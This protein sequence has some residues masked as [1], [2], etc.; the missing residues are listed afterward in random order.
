MQPQALYRVAVNDYIAAGGS[1]FEVLKRNTTK[2]DT[3]VS[4]RDAL[5][6]YLNTRT[7]CTDQVD[8][9]V[10]PPMLVTQ[11]YGDISCLDETVEAHDGR[12]ASSSSSRPPAPRTVP[13]S[14]GR[15]RSR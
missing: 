3:G 2:Q 8:M 7:T 12:S 6:T 13:A 15:S 11:R 5:R 9:Q 1:G 10:E 4:L 14:P